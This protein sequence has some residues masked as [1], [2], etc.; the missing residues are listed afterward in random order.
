MTT[1][2]DA[3]IGATGEELEG[4]AEELEIPA[5]LPPTKRSTRS[6]RASAPIG[7]PAGSLETRLSLMGDNLD[8]VFRQIAGQA[9]AMGE[10]REA[11]SGVT[12]ELRATMG[13]MQRQ[14]GDHDAQLERLRIAIA[15]S[16]EVER[17]L[18]E[19]LVHVERAR[20]R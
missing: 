17:R 5:A 18:R 7:P 14:V 16:I 12:E 19:V 1:P 15:A 6:S 10:M 9:R 2:L 4:A 11:V 20:D 8:L 3:S 13:L